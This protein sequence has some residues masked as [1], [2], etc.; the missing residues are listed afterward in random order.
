[1]GV[2][3]VE[4]AGRA[5]VFFDAYH[6]GALGVVIGLCLLCAYWRHRAGP[7][8]RAAFRYGVPVVLLAN[9]AVWLVWLR[10]TDQWSL[11]TILPLHLCSVMVYIGSAALVTRRQSLYEPL[12]FLGIGGAVQALL[13][14]NLGPRGF[15]H[16]H[17]ISSFV[18]HGLILAAPV[19]LT[20]VEGLRPRW[21]SLGRVF[22][23]G[24]VYMAFVGAVNR[25]TGSNYMY[26]SHKPET[27]TLLDALGPW[28]WYILGMEAI[29]LITMLGLYVP[30]AVADARRAARPTIR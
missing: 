17:F 2:F 28:P 1:M 24:N 16:I 29:G 21:A 13:T 26:I 27:P 23:A 14:P 18:S 12:Y 20:L 7:R 25:M 6:L 19:Y 5:F 4:G 22:V 11:R 9:E 15:P 10:A 30:F 3:A 8:L